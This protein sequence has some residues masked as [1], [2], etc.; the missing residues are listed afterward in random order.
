VVDNG[1]SGV[2]VKPADVSD[3]AAAVA[4]L[5]RDPGQWAQMSLR[6][7]QRVS[8][9]FSLEAMGRQYLKLIQDSLHGKY[10]VPWPR[11]CQLPLDI[12]L[13]PVREGLPLPVRAVARNVRD[14]MAPAFSALGS[15][16]RS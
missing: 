3:F 9:F 5:S 2:L 11:T 16:R 14:F 1:Q 15:L 13:F 8:R 12:S 7:H 4:R 6:A 10:P